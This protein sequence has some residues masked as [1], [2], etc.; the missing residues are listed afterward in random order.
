[1][2]AD[3][4]LDYVDARRYWPCN[5]GISFEKVIADIEAGK[6]RLEDY[7]FLSHQQLQSFKLAINSNNYLPTVPMVTVPQP[8]QAGVIPLNKPDENSLV[9]VTGNNQYTVNVLISVWSQGS[10][11]AYLVIVDCLGSTVDMAMI[12]GD[13][14]PVRLQQALMNNHLGERVSHRHMIIPG[15]T[16]PLASYFREATGWEIETGPICAAELPLALGDR[17]IFSP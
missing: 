14:S 6:T 9:I 7:S 3:L 17:W 8:T 16:S 13:F 11:P 2:D 12:F 15:L 5:A 10:T 4:Y 1:M